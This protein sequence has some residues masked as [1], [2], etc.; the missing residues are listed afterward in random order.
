MVTPI[1]YLADD[2]LVISLDFGTTF[3]GVAYAFNIPGKKAD[4]VSIL[5]WPGLEGFRQPKVPTL[6]LYDENDPSKFK[7]GGQVNWRDP[8][9]Q[10]VKLLLDPDQPKPA[11]LPVSS[12][13]KDRKMLPK[14]PV[15]VAADFLGAIYNHALATIESAGVRDYFQFCQKEFI[16][17]V[18][19]VWSDKAKDLTLKVRLFSSA[20]KKAG[21]HPVTLIKEPEAAALYTLSSHDHSLNVGDSF[22]VCDAGGGTV[23]L[24]TYEV[25]KMEPYL[26]LA[27]LVPGTG[28]MAGSLGLNK[29]FEEA[30]RL[31]VGEEQF[32]NLKKSVGWSKASN[33]FDKNIKTAFNGDITDV[34]YLNF[35]KAELEDDPV[36][37][38]FDNCWEMTGDVLQDIFDP[39]IRDILRLVDAQGIFL[40]GGFGSS[41]YLKQRLQ[42]EYETIQ[43]IQPHDAWG[44]IVKGAVLSR[45]ANQ[46]SIVSTQAVRHYGTSAWSEINP[47]VDSGRPVK[48]DAYDGK[49]RV[50]KMTWYIY[51]G[52]DLKRDQ[53]IKFSFYRALTESQLDYNLIFTD[54]LSYSE[55]KVAPTYPGPDVKVCCELRSDLSG[56]NKDLFEKR[57]GL[58]GKVYYLVHYQLVLSTDAAN[59]R[60]SLEIDGT[61]MGSV[62]AKY[63]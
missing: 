15:D 50:Q 38:L 23:D 26:Q 9:V 21:I 33:E 17:T 24:I 19:A 1:A 30:V 59:M 35:P 13:K 48:Y 58:D 60:F 41:R 54:A 63:T 56:V 51:I 22:V 55:S 18:P 4:V 37:R 42:T 10:G 14:D 16:L 7:W 45:V 43:V 62:E 53:P 47:I 57:T 49:T 2:R 32:Y 31:V 25:T 36:E 46:A 20:A 61:K 8:A 5:D 39:I 28:G 52:E 11:Y 12:F 44:A 40:V 34:H 6:I 3:S 29:R 27:E